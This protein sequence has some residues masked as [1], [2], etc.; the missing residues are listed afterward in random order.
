MKWKHRQKAKA[1]A[2][3]TQITTSKARIE[4]GS[5]NTDLEPSILRF[6]TGPQMVQKPSL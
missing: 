6:K 1:L 3:I 2:S 4:L 5:L